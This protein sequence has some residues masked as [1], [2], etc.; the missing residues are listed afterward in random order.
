MRVLGWCVLLTVS[1]L[2]CLCWILVFA[3]IK[4]DAWC[5]K[6]RWQQSAPTQ[7]CDQGREVA[8]SL[9]SR[10]SKP[11]SSPRAAAVEASQSSWW[12]KRALRPLSDASFLC[13][14]SHELGAPSLQRKEQ[15]KSRKQEE[16]RAT[17]SWK[18]REWGKSRSAKH[19]QKHV[20]PYSHTVLWTLAKKKKRHTS[21]AQKIDHQ[22]LSRGKNGCQQPY[23]Q[24]LSGPNPE[25]GM[26]TSF[27]AVRT[28][29]H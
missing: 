15:G 13:R 18:P 25:E 1:I 17:F 12:G 26:G 22:T 23:N 5:P 29:K 10:V 20:P 4:W 7:L 19:Q 2:W 8:L 11:K 28:A 24:L 16:Y 21:Y 27:S 9:W 3:L 6:V 14:K